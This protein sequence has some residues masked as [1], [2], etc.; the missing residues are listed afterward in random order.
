MAATGKKIKS[1]PAETR[2]LCHCYLHYKGL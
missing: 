1:I 2:T